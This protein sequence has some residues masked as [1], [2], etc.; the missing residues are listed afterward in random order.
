MQAAGDVA[1]LAD[2]VEPGHG[3]LSLREQCKLLGVSRSSLSYR[4]KQ[5]EGDAELRRALDK[6]Y[7]EDPTLGSRRLPE[8]LARDYGL[9]AGRKRVGRIRREM[10]LEAI[11]CRPKTSVPAP[12]HR[13]FPYLLR[14]LAISQ[15][16]HVWCADITYIP[17]REG[18]G[19]LCA[20]MD[21]NSRAVLG[22]QFSNTMDAS[23]SL[24]ALEMALKR[25]GTVPEIF[26]TDQGSQFTCEPWIKRLESLGVQVSMDGK[27]RWMD[28][29]FIERLWRSLKYEEIYLRD[30]DSLEEQRRA[31]ARWVERYNHWRPHQSLGNAVPWAVYRK[32][33][34]KEAA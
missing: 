13:I 17:M 5:K 25:A 14:N 22:W 15:P 24:S 7:M 23:L 8:V 26:N 11:Y 3:S 20:G 28:N 30:R 27:G 33:V 9:S 16:D 2:L 12:G 34:K 6:I 4:P 32:A 19:Y 21:R 29:I 18:H 31:I 10:G 1:R